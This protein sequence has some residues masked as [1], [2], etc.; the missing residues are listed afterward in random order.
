MDPVRNPYAPGAGQRPPELAGRD[1]QLDRFRVVLERIQRGRPER[2]M[3]LTGLRGVGKTVLLNALRGATRRALEIWALAAASALPTYATVWLTGNTINVAVT[4]LVAPLFVR[5]GIATRVEIASLPGVFQETRDSL[6]REVTGLAALGEGDLDESFRALVEFADLVPEEVDVR[7]A[8]A[9]R[10]AYHL[11][12]T[13]TLKAAELVA[14][15]GIEGSFKMFADLKLEALAGLKPR[16]ISDAAKLPG[17]RIIEGQITAVQQSIGTPKSR[18]T[19][20]RFV[21]VGRGAICAGRIIASAA[22][23]IC[24]RCGRVISISG[25]RLRSGRRQSAESALRRLG[26]ASS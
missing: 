13:R 17:S 12:L 11:F 1:E 16:L 8:V 18:E 24:S 5:E 7:I 20:A 22:A 23:I 9:D 2:S 15:D 3:I 6:C 10:S 14:A 25:S 26:F 21:M 19:G 4:D